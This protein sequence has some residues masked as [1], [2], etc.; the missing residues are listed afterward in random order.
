VLRGEHGEWVSAIGYPQNLD[1]I[2]GW[3]GLRPPLNRIETTFAP[4]DRALVI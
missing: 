4:G 2:E 3:T 1:L